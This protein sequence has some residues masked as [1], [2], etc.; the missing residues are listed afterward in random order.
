MTAMPAL[1][2]RM[3]G[4]HASLPERINQRV[5]TGLSPR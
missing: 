4:I 1:A 5:G 3:D 2:P